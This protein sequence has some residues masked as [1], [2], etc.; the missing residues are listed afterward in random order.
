MTFKVDQNHGNEKKVEYEK[1]AVGSRN[2]NEGNGV[3]EVIENRIYVGGVPTWMDENQ[4]H[5]Y[6]TKFGQVEHVTIIDKSY[7]QQYSTNRYG[8]I[9]FRSCSLHAVKKLLYNTDPQEL[10]VQGGRTLTVGPAKKGRNKY[11]PSNWAGGRGGD[12]HGYYVDHRRRPVHHHQWVKR[13]DKGPHQEERIIPPRKREDKSIDGGDDSKSNTDR[14][15]EFPDGPEVQVQG[16][17][18]E[19]F[20]GPP[21]DMSTMV[22]P[23][24]YQQPMPVGGQP[25]YEYPGMMY[26]PLPYPSIQS[27][28][29]PMMTPQGYTGY[30]DYS[31]SEQ[32]MIMP[33]YQGGGAVYWPGASVPVL[34]PSNPHPQC[35]SQP[36]LG[37]YPPMDYSLLQQPQPVDILSDSGYHD[38]TSTSTASGSIL[39]GG[40]V[41]QVQES[42]G[43]HQNQGLEKEMDSSPIL[44]LSHVLNNPEAVQGQMAAPTDAV[45]KQ[46]HPMFSTQMGMDRTRC[47]NTPY[48]QF[49]QFTGGQHLDPQG[50]KFPFVNKG[51]KPRRHSVKEVLQRNE[52]IQDSMTIIQ[53]SNQDDR[54]M[55]TKRDQPQKRLQTEN[56]PDLLRDSLHQNLIIK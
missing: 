4:L 42:S 36:G 12:G 26:P 27:I 54:E 1:M 20:L 14:V 8:F 2:G 3:E 13:G 39:Y 33:S 48:K 25:G 40:D 30:Y 53:P 55:N 41:S 34:Y 49:T 5:E 23:P 45:M 56:Q 32:F 6:F 50:N 47:Y 17:A 52:K 10:K 11:G 35:Y 22:M 28:H 31:Y 21:A 44:N 37:Y 46:Q 15:E 24:Q 38:L 51:G 43:V 19:P 29:P 16:P 18:M 9:T 7:T